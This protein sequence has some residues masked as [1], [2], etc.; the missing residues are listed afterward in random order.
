MTL[1]A[2][3]L[4]LQRLTTR[5]PIARPGRGL[6]PGAPARHG[7]ERLAE[8]PEQR[9]LESRVGSRWLAMMLLASSPAKAEIA[10]WEGTRRRAGSGRR[11]GAEHRHRSSSRSTIASRVDI[12]EGQDE[13][14][15]AARSSAR[16]VLRHVAGQ[17]ARAPG[18][19]RRSGCTSAARSR[20]TRSRA[21]GIGSSP[22]HIAASAVA[23]AADAETFA[24]AARGCRRGL[25]VLGADQGE[26]YRHRRR[27][28]RGGNA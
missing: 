21:P 19:L 15:R 27:D 26:R 1:L 11:Q 5:E 3:G 14:R 17:R 9:K 25:P 23:P 2:P 8:T 18:Q 12:V 6:D 16:D 7:E 22:R 13:P 28:T 20:W 24:A 4:W 10:H